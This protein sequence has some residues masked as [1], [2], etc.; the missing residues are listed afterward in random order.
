MDGILP[1]AG[2][3]SR[4]RGIPKFLLP[5][6]KDYVS[7][8][9]VHISNLSNICDKI[10]LPTRP[11]LAPVI[12]SLDFNFK[13]TEIPEM[14]T[15]TMCETVN[16][17]LSISEADN[18]ILIMPDTFF[19]GDQPYDILD[20]TTDLC[21][22]ACWKIR[23]EQRGKLGEVRFDVNNKVVEMV[24]K[25]P[26]NG[27]EY[28]WGALTFSRKLSQYIDNKDPHIGYAAKKSVKNGEKVTV[29]LMNGSYFD[30]GTPDEYIKLLQKTLLS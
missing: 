19:L 21:N 7:L 5:V 11:E 13:N 1:A 26:D 15:S 22:L 12:K 18:F 9:E 6:D 25:E 29:S 20:S 24:D 8:L 16:N 27:F 4:M 28:A 2:L 3:A 14:V 10:Y 23:D 30:C 17:T